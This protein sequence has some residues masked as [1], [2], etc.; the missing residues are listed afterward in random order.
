MLT[1]LDKKHITQISNLERIL[2]CERSKAMIKML[3][4]QRQQRV[5]KIDKDNVCSSNEA[6]NPDSI[7]PESNLSSN[8]IEAINGNNSTENS[9]FNNVN[10]S[11]PDKSGLANSNPVFRL[12]N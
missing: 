9:N 4:L 1:N 10:W 2:K 12:I 8:I 7:L 11:N 5:S 3:N 6:I